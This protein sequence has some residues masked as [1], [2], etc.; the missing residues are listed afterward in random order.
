[1]QIA[2]ITITR[3]NVEGLRRTITSVRCQTYADILHVIIDG[4][5]T[6]GTAE[7][8]DAERRNGTAMVETAPPAGVYDAIN[9]GIRVALDAGADVIGLLHAGDTYAS[10][11][12]VAQVA[13]A[14]DEGDI[15]FVYGDLHYSRAGSDKVLRYYGAAHFTPAMLRQGYAPGHPTLYLTRR[16]AQVAGP[17]DT[18]FRV[19][20]DFEMWLRLFEHT[21]LRPR[22]LP[23]DM[24][25]MDTGGLS[26]R[27]YSRLVTNNRERLRSFRM[28][29]LPASHL[30]ILRHYTHV[31]KSFI[32]RKQR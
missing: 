24:V 25:C 14:F 13:E 4:D 12:V 30:N 22:Y 3:N 28:H 19:G 20:V 26:Q 23:L 10:D 6:D 7:V 9:R 11:D 32:C 21:E 8:L 18:G 27:W 16:A 1:M 29:G 5:S 17:Y 15:D 31:L 2:V